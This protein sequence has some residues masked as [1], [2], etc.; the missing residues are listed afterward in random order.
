VLYVDGE[1]YV[2]RS[3]LEVVRAD[4]EFGRDHWT[5]Q[6]RADGVELEGTV[7]SSSDKMAVVTY[8]DTGGENLWCHNSKLADLTLRLRDPERSGT[9]TLRST[10][11][12]AYEYVTRNVPE[13]PVDL[14]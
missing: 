4:T 10:G 14:E 12:A 1:R 2:F 5:F 9:I 11:R 6:T 8:E 13:G 7:R 3:A